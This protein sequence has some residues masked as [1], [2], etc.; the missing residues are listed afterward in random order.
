MFY[1]FSLLPT[2]LDMEYRFYIIDYGLIGTESIQA[3]LKSDIRIVCAVA[4]TW[5]M[6]SIIK[7][8]R[9]LDKPDEVSFLFSFVSKS[10]RADIRGL[11]AEHTHKVFF[12]DYEDSLFSRDTGIGLCGEIFKDYLREREERTQTSSLK[13]RLLWFGKNKQKASREKG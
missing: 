6:A 3:F 9:M 13:Y 10:E 12:A 7:A 4:K 11:M 5:E 2:L 1:D 8:V